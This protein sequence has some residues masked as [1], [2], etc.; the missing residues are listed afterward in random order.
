M[1]KRQLFSLA[2]DDI[3][4][5]MIAEGMSE[6]D[7]RIAVTHRLG[8]ISSD[9]TVVKLGDEMPHPRTYCAF[10]GVLSEFVRDE[11]LLSLE[12]AVYKMS[13]FPAWKLGLY[14]RGVIKPEA[15]ADIVVLDIWKMRCESRFG[16]PHHYTEGITPVSYTHL[17]AQKCFLP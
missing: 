17:E 11:S 14:D 12:E 7:N 5:A 4:I 8:M 1:Y 15:K 6:E 3:D 13:G 16:D 2:E 9:S 10:S